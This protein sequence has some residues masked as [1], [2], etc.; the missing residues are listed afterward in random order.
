MQNYAAVRD[1]LEALGAAGSTAAQRVERQVLLKVASDFAE[2]LA[3]VDDVQGQIGVVMDAMNDT[4]PSVRV[5]ELRRQDDE[6]QARVAAAGAEVAQIR[7]MMADADAAGGADDPCTFAMS[8]AQQAAEARRRMEEEARTQAAE[9]QRRRRANALQSKTEAEA[10]RAAEQ[11]RRYLAE[12]QLKEARAAAEAHAVAA[13]AEATDRRRAEIK[14]MEDDKAA[15]RVERLEMERAA[16]RQAEEMSKALQHEKQAERDAG[17]RAEVARVEARREQIAEKRRIE[18]DDQAVAASIEAER[19]RH[20]REVRKAA[21]LEKAAAAEAH[22]GEQRRLGA[23]RHGAHVAARGHKEAEEKARF[24]DTAAKRKGER[25]ASARRREV[26]EDAAALDDAQRRE[27]RAMTQD[28]ARV[29]IQ[30]ESAATVFAADPATAARKSRHEFRA[31]MAASAQKLEERTASLAAGDAAAAAAEEADVVEKKEAEDERGEEVEMA[32]TARGTG[33]AERQSEEEADIAGELASQKAVLAA[34]L[35]VEEAAALLQAEAAAPAV[36]EE[37]EQARLVSEVQGEAAQALPPLAKTEDVRVEAPEA[38]GAVHLRGQPGTPLGN[39]AVASPAHEAAHGSGKDMAKQAAAAATAKHLEEMRAADSVSREL[40]AKETTQ[41]TAADNVQVADNAQAATDDTQAAAVDTQAATKDT[42]AATAVS[43]AEE[44]AGREGPEAVVAAEVLVV[45][46]GEAPLGAEKEDADEGLGVVTVA[47]AEGT[48]DADAAVLRE[49][50]PAADDEDA[51]AAPTPEAADSAAQEVAERE[52]HEV[53]LKHEVALQRAA[54]EAELAEEEQRVTG[55]EA[56]KITDASAVEGEGE[57]ANAGENQAEREHEGVVGEEA[58]LPNERVVEGVQRM[59]EAAQAATDNT[60]AASE[61]AQAATID[62]QAAA[63]R[64]QAAQRGKAARKLVAGM[65]CGSDD[66]GVLDTQT[67]QATVATDNAQVAINVQ[68]ATDD[69]QAASE[70]TQ[71]ASEDTQAA[72]IDTQA[73]ATTNADQPFAPVSA[74]DTPPPPTASAAAAESPFPSGMD[75]TAATV[76]IHPAHCGHAARKQVETL[77]GVVETAGPDES[78]AHI[79]EEFE[80]QRAEVEAELSVEAANAV[81]ASAVDEKA[82]A[83]VEPAAPADPLGVSTDPAAPVVS[84]HSDA[85]SAPAPA[86]E[87]APATPT[88]DDRTPADGAGRPVPTNEI[89]RAGPDPA[90]PAA[91]N[92]AADDDPTAA[93]AAVDAAAD[94]NLAIH[95]QTEA[96]AAIT[97]QSVQRGRAARR[98]VTSIKAERAGAELAAEFD[99]ELE[100]S[101]GIVIIAAEA[102]EGDMMG[103]HPGP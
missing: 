27:E 9:A 1:S 23:E 4:R 74:E 29:H 68:A 55:A 48:A 41:A 96:E 24:M 67:T 15:Q 63:I 57:G 71:A 22:A 36:E 21:A 93:A 40:A 30:H 20:L 43:A 97:I 69:T 65:K 79:Q 85:S 60:Q 81:L 5:L 16:R 90:V 42:Q 11:E 19:Q 80:R 34:E 58:E 35:A 28:A 38:E 53:A 32:A 49:A 70:D 88:A 18:R 101:S 3:P 50:D 83:P 37:N 45:A 6:E 94:D 76:K 10:R 73:S 98:K 103:V 59:N 54:L 61:D 95:A 99:G 77:R 39:T 13:K 52:A 75:V 33:G 78:G 14:A 47:D 25:E 82:P 7:A 17:K 8:V 87:F 2:Q 12:Q 86:G 26:V 102:V 66:A 56:E 31:A 64:I 51:A 46:S 100:M 91:D 72:L 92:P 89:V 44:V 84:L 62:T